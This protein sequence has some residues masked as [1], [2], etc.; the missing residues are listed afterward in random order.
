MIRK[1]PQIKFSQFINSIKTS[2][3]NP[4]WHQ[5]PHEN[6][7]RMHACKS[8]TRALPSG[9]GLHEQRTT[10]RKSLTTFLMKSFILVLLQAS[11]I[12]K[13]TFGTSKDE[14][15]VKRNIYRTLY[16]VNARVPNSRANIGSTCKIMGPWR[17]FLIKNYIKFIYFSLLAFR[18]SSARARCNYLLTR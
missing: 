2:S 10:R 1:F 18:L 5:K 7:P 13:K 15:T 9:I 12:S 4:I 16:S 17:K 6:F 14:S 3:S 8:S 11:A